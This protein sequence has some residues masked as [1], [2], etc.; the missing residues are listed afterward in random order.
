M[1]T[2]KPLSKDMSAKVDCPGCYDHAEV[3]L[4]DS[5]DGRSCVMIQKYMDIF[6][7]RV[8]KMEVYED[9]V[10]VVTF[11]KCGTTWT[12][13]KSQT[14]RLISHKLLSNTARNGL[15]DQQ[16]LGLKNG[17]RNQPQRPIPVP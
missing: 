8:K 13:R 9:D 17:S 6:A 14:H 7:E 15:D 10:W 4:K 12:V 2:I 16:Q 11:P 3:S 5:N 1:F